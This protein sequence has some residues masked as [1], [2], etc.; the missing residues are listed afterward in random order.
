MFE[1][2]AEFTSEA[3]DIVSAIVVLRQT[4]EDDNIC[5][6]LSAI[7]A[8]DPEEARSPHLS[9]SVPQCLMIH[10]QARNCTVQECFVPE[11]EKLD[12]FGHVRGVMTEVCAVDLSSQPLNLQISIDNLR[13]QTVTRQLLAIF[14]ASSGYRL[15]FDNWRISVSTAK[16]TNILGIWSYDCSNEELDIRGVSGAISLQF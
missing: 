6:S 10:E 8:K 1:S 14:L 3:V 5:F 15:D 16:K 9:A 11:T 12:E 2:N 4:R 13:N 7:S